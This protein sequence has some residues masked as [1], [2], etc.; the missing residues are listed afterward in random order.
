MDPIVI[1]ADLVAMCGLYCGACP[2]YQKKKCPGCRE[3]HS[4]RWCA[5]RTCALEKHCGSCADCGMYPDPGTD[6]RKLNNPISK[7]FAFFFNSNRAACLRR[8][9]SV[10]REN[11]AREMAALGRPS[12]PRKAKENA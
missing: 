1:D 2:S 7:V 10:G 4:A 3:N 6:C 12:L 5:T 11:F 9:R 8:I